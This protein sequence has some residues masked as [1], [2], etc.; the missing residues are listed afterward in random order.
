[1]L[2]GTAAAYSEQV[3]VGRNVEQEDAQ[4]EQGYMDRPLRGRLQPVYEPMG[5]SISGEQDNLKEKHARDPD[6]CRPAEPR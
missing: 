4:H 5:V 6:R 1:M 3:T 2:N